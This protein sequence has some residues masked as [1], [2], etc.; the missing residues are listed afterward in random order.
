MSRIASLSLGLLLVLGGCSLSRPAA[1]PSSAASTSAA[2]RA[3]ARGDAASGPKPYAQVVTDSLSHDAGLFTV[4]LDAARATL[5][6]EIPDS[7]FGRE[8][9]LVSR[10][11]RTAEGYGYG[12]TKTGT[13]AVRWER[14]GDHVL[15][16]TV[17]YASV[18]AD[19]LPIYRAV[20]NAQ[21]EPVV[22]RVPVRAYGP[23]SSAVV[24]LTALFTGDTPALGLPAQA[25]EQFKVRKLDA[26]RSYL[27]RAS[28]YPL[29]VEV[30]SVLT[31]DAAEP[32]TNAAT[33]TLSVEM[34]H[35]MVLLPA[36]PMRPRRADPR[37]GYFAI[38]QTDYGLDA[39]RAEPRRYVTR[40]RLEPSD[41]AAYA[42]G[43]LVEPVT[44]ITYYID[45]ATPVQ[46]RPYL[47]QGVEDWNLAFEAA[48]FRNAIRAMDPPADDPDWSP[49]DIRYSVIRYFPSD[50]E[51]AYGPHVHDPRSGEILEADI[52]W[53]HNVMNLLRN[54]FFVQTAAANPDAR[55]PRFRE[56]VMGELV[57]FVSAHEVGHTLGL[58]HN[59]ISSSSIPVDSL[60]SPAYTAANGTA[61]SIMDYARFNYVAQPGDGVT[62][63]MPRVGPYDLWS[64]EWG[65]RAFPDAASEEEER[66]RLQAMTTARAGDPTLQYGAQTSDPVDPRSQSED[67]GDDA[68]Y[69][70]TLGLANLKRIVPNLTQWTAEPGEDYSTLD[71]L[72]GQVV[73]QWGR[74]LGH[75]TRQVG[76]VT[77]S[78]RLADQDV[79]I[80]V[81]VEADRQ[82]AAVRFVLDEGFARPDWLLDADLLARIEPAGAADRV[83]R[84]QETALASLLNPV[85]LNRLAEAEWTARAGQDVYT[86]PAMLADLRAGVWAETAA[87]AA[88]AP[89]RRALQHAHVDRLADL[90]DADAEPMPAARQQAIYGYRSLAADRSD[91]RPLARGELVALQKQLRRALSRYTS[92]ARRMERLHLEDALA[93]IDATLDPD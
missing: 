50:I 5:L 72:Y 92:S 67:L 22:A 81:P 77:I 80:Y 57:R 78:P 7:L 14:V 17:R 64:V 1:T 8:M 69:A 28:A 46:W 86:A 59:W 73:N 34:A 13:Q 85:R 4:H 44:P 19:S 36:V 42:R 53:Y 65:Y 21:F 6:A 35:S 20:R 10:V 25:R 61:P 58:P 47:K 38:G 11:A 3:G 88:I 41:P 89:S 76:G 23:D 51:N 71:E 54:W 33:G 84:V 91:V 79:P 26:A 29:N 70:S 24:D 52:G 63:F 45:P 12:G 31:Y 30:R 27:A 75:V 66:R 37:V 83:A 90:L 93:R 49:E 39:Q 16:R 43:E 87:G 68:V 48:G 32:P 74:Y 2:S 40:W 18:A 82:R 15:L 60:R 55:A 62:Q 9:L 56:A